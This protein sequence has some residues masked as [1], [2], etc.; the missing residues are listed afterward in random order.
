[1]TSTIKTV[2]FDIPWLLFCLINFRTPCWMKAESI[3]SRFI[4]LII[5][6]ILSGCKIK[7]TKG[8][9]EVNGARLYYEIYGN[10]TPLILIH[11]WTFDSRCWEYQVPVLSKNYQVFGYDLRGFGKSSLPVQGKSYSHTKDLVALMDYLGIERAILLGHSFGGRI[12]I[13]CAINYPERVIGLILPEGAWD[14]NDVDLGDDF[15]ELINWLVS[16]REAAENEGIEKAKANWMN[17]PPFLTAMQKPHSASLVK[18]MVNEYS[19]W[20]YMHDDPAQGFESYSVIKLKSISAPTLI[21]YGKNSPVGYFRIAQIQ[22]EYIP[23]SKLV[24]IDNAAHALNI[25]N[26]DQFNKEILNFLK[27]SNFK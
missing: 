26:P 8:F 23:I 4:P 10:G 25:E 16:T 21:M 3:F 15:D 7:L 24:T 18:K 22:H 5:I 17:G 13:D 1:M 20:H 19:W 11:G 2:F 14:V 6:V 12:A 27:E 9:A